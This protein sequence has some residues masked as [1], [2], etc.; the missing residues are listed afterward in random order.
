LCLITPLVICLD[1]Q[2]PV[3]P[4]TAEEIQR[5]RELVEAGALPRKKLEE[6]EWAAAEARDQ[7]TLKNTLFGHLT[8]E[9]FTEEQ[10]RDMMAAAERQFQ[11]RKD[12]LET[13]KKLVAAG[14]QPVNSLVPHLEEFDRSR[15]IFDSAAARLR[16]FQELTEMVRAEQEAEQRIAELEQEHRLT[17]RYDGSTLVSATHL[18]FIE[19]SFELEFKQALPVSARGETLLHVSM[20]FD[21]RGR[22][23]IALHPDSKEGGWLRRQLEML[24]VPYLAFRGSIPGQSTGAHIHIG[25]PSSRI[26][27]TD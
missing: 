18:G 26:R 2:P 24:R 27:R 17:E 12:R 11:R 7:E 19:R 23:D 15:K 16:L 8:L 25:P 20:G 6:A 9:L 1:A 21:H 10:S 22:I 4:P 14:V 13:A 3:L 5:M